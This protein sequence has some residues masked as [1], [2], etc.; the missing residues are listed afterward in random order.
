MIDG[1]R[2]KRRI[3]AFLVLAAIAIASVAVARSEPTVTISANE[4][5]EGDLYLSAKTATI[6]GT[7]RGNAIIAAE[8]VTLNGTVEGDVYLAAETIAIAGTVKGDAVAVGRSIRIEG[9]VEEDALVFG[10]GVDIDGT[11]GDDVRMAGEVLRLNAR[12]RV[13]DDAIAAGYS[14][15]SRVGSLVEGNFNVAGARALLAGTVEGNLVGAIASVAFHGW[16]DG[17]VTLGVGDEQ[18]FR[19]PFIPNPPLAM[20]EVPAGLTV[21]NSAAIGGNF[22]YR[23]PPNV[24]NIGEKAQIAGE[25]VREPGAVPRQPPAGQPYLAVAIA[26]LRRF[27]T[28]AAVGLVLL[29]LKP[30][31]LHVLAQTVQAKPGSSLGWGLLSLG[32]IAIATVAIALLTGLLVV[33]F[34]LTFQG[35]VLPVLGF[36]LLANLALLVGFGSFIGFVPQIALSYLGGRAA[37]QKMRPDWAAKDWVSLCLGLAGFVA[38]ATVPIAGTIF[39]S[40]SICLGLGALALQVKQRWG[41]HLSLPQPRKRY[42][43][44]EV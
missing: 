34:A 8:I 39:G 12:S 43:K 23:V 13:G 28:L 35:L 41:S 6:D 18:P 2:W 11:I 24:A 19:P 37:L 42:Q 25:V 30:R 14:V 17:D 40:A 33:L 1:I 16:V 4:T 15:E 3:V 22:T 21:A 27:F 26:S 31:G 44:N 9:T 36:G 29:Q 7:I 38:I 32:A 10:Q 5:L 20:P